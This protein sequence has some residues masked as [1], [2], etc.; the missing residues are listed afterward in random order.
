ME[1]DLAERGRKNIGRDRILAGIT[2]EKSS[3]KLDGNEVKYCEFIM[4]N[5]AALLRIETKILAQ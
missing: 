5:F 2:G 3:K 1:V 4:G